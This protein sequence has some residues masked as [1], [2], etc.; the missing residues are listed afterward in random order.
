MAFLWPSYPEWVWACLQTHVSLAILVQPFAGRHRQSLVLPHGGLAMDR[1]RCW[2]EGSSP[3]VLAVSPY[4]EHCGLIRWRAVPLSVC[5][6][7]GESTSIQ[8]LPIWGWGSHDLLSL[9]ATTGQT[10]AL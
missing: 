2:S 10:T 1:V 4:W 5:H 7:C 6:D 8:N 9:N 3:P